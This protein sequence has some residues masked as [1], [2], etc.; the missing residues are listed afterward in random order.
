MTRTDYVK[1]AN[2]LC[3]MEQNKTFL[4]VLERLS[5][6]FKRDNSRFSKVRF[7]EACGVIKKEE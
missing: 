3:G 2:I 7:F 4:E 1:I 6:M 5:E